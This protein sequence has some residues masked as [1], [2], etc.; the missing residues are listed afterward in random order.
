MKNEIVEKTV[1]QKVVYE[2]ARVAKRCLGVDGAF[3]DEDR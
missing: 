2:G 1:A 3:D